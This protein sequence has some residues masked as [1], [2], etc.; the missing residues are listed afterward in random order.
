M[1][2]SKAFLPVSRGIVTISYR[3]CVAFP[4]R[5]KY[6]SKCQLAQR[7]WTRKGKKLKCLLKG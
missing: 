7:L 1:K 3:H 4:I 6:D 2:V 5:L